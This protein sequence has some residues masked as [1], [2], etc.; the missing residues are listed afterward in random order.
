VIFYELD[1][2]HGD[3]ALLRVEFGMTILTFLS[4]CMQ[5]VVCVIMDS[6]IHLASGRI[7]SYSYNAPKVHGKDDITGEDLIQREDDKPEAIRKRLASYVKVSSQYC[8]VYQGGLW[9]GN[10]LTCE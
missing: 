8:D 7:Y 1:G 4:A 6:W 10:V 3:A 9:F 2:F 5:F